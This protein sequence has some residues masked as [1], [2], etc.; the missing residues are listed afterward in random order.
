MVDPFIYPTKICCNAYY[1]LTALDMR[2]HPM[3]ICHEYFLVN[4]INQGHKA[5]VVSKH[6]KSFA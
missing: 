6:E 3:L 5:F 1:L 2:I 4:Y